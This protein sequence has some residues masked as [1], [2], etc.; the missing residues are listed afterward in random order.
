MLSALLACHEVTSAAV[1]VSATPE[2][3]CHARDFGIADLENGFDCSH[4][5][6]LKWE[7]LF[8]FHFDIEVSF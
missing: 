8:S 4:N 1:N 2:S 3:T 5:T 6:I 7:T